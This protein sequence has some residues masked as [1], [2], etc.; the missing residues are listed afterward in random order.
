[1][2]N[3]VDYDDACAKYASNLALRLE[4]K[5]VVAPEIE[6]EEMEA[7]EEGKNE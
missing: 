1:M 4:G 2:P 6:E 5:T 7:V 3:K